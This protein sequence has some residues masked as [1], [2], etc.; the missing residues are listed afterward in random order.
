MTSPVLLPPNGVHR[1]YR[2]GPAIAALRGAEPPP[3]SADDHVPEDWVGSTTEAFGEPGVGLSALPGGALLRDAVAADPAGWLGPDH[4]ARWGADPA[5]LVKLLDA[6][7]RLPVHVH[8][9]GP[10]ARERLGTRFGK[11]E[12]WI[13]IGGSGPVHLGW[14]DDVSDVQLRAWIDTQDAEAMLAALHRIDLEAGD[15]VFVPAGVP[16]A[17]G[18]GLLIAELQEPSDMSVMLEWQGHGIADEAE[19]TLRLGWDAALACVERGARDPAA[20]AGPARDGDPATG[21]ALPGIADPFFTATW[22]TARPTAPVL[23]PAAGFCVLVVLDGGGRLETADG[24]TLS[25]ARGDNVVIPY[26][27]GVARLS[28]TVRA[29]ACR[30][31][32]P[33]LPEVSS[34]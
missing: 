32:D 11:T 2:G 16:H 24:A 20:L 3:A 1:F 8:P 10:F 23:L 27:A 25:L 14:R 34:R 28:G 26:S 12:A 31:P 15:A 17:I 13:V 22:L 19:A 21:R 7:E 33:A 6:G 5:L 9:G 29:L 30:P 4:V 18:A